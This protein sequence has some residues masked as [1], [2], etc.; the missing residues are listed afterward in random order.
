MCPLFGGLVP[1]SS[2]GY[3]LVHIVVPPMGLQTP[4]AP[5]VLS[6]APHIILLLFTVARCASGLLHS[7][8]LAALIYISSLSSPLNVDETSPG[9]ILLIL[10]LLTCMIALLSILA[11]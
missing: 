11:N 4:L 7:R 1:G 9:T 6:L 3:W 8:Q 10:A 2:G 5:Q